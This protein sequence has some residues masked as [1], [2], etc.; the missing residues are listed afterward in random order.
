[1]TAQFLLTAAIGHRPMTKTFSL[2]SRTLFALAIAV[3]AFDIAC[4]GGTTND[5]AS[6]D[7]GIDDSDDSPTG[8]DAPY[9][10]DSGVS[11][12]AGPDAI[13]PQAW[14]VYGNTDPSSD[15]GHVDP[16]LIA[17]GECYGSF[18]EFSD[19][20]GAPADFTMT[21]TQSAPG[22]G[23]FVT[24]LS[25]TIPFALNRTVCLQSSGPN[26]GS[27]GYP[28]DGGQMCLT[29][30][31]EDQI[32]WDPNVVTF[33]NL[34]DSDAGVFIN[35]NQSTDGGAASVTNGWCRWVKN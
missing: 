8:T 28:D 22:S 20:G 26:T 9:N 5:G 24:Q 7:A 17:S 12:D 27:A 1:M 10:F 30:V 14:D 16:R 19:A 4:G 35:L 23:M 18:E 31:T 34:E 15:L 25:Q 2:L 6:N 29:D 13:C 33:T 21:M 3:P 32:P 11:N